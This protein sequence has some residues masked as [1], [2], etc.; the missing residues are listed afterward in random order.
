MEIV[1]QGG[2]SNDNFG[3]ADDTIL[4]TGKETN[5]ETYWVLWLKLK[6]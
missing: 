4:L 3:L 6:I 5:S 2:Q 1:Q